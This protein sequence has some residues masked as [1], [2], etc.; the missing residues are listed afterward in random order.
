MTCKCATVYVGP[1]PVG[2]NWN[3]DCPDHPWND[4]LQ[5]QADRA[6]EMQRKA[7]EARRRATQ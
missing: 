4:R 1:T 3:P 7:A 5:A 2:K 6:V